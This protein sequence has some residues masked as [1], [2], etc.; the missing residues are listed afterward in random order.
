VEFLFDLLPLLVIYVL[1]RVFARKRTPTPPT[2]S[3]STEDGAPTARTG[4]EHLLEALAAAQAEAERAASGE[5]AIPTVE[6]PPAAPPPTG[7]DP[8]S[9]PRKARKTS[10]PLQPAATVSRGR[11]GAES[12]R[13]YDDETVF[14]RAAPAHAHDDHA[15]IDA[16]G[17]ATA[18]FVEHGMRSHAPLDAPIGPPPRPASGIAARLRNPTT[19]REAFEI[20]MLLERRG[21]SASEQRRLGASPRRP[22][23]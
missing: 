13:F 3:V 10:A 12:G 6:A 22:T 14:D 16:D 7:A 18:N 23:R 1:V 5:P 21:R 15:G 9:R 8:T 19:A 17:F 2:E 4:F 11:P 20:Q